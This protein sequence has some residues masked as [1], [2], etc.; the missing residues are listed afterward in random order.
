MDRD[1]NGHR[2]MPW[3][4]SLSVIAATV[5]SG[6]YG[7]TN[8]I[9]PQRRKELMRRLRIKRQVTQE[10]SRRL[11]AV[12]ARSRANI[13]NEQTITTIERLRRK[14]DCAVCELRASGAVMR[15]AVSEVRKYRDDLDQ[16][17]PIDTWRR[18]LEGK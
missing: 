3:L 14:L 2:T 11:A 6:L 5:F 18:S 7:W 12:C 8:L 1:A 4:S 10:E 16:C 17:G 15:E 9:E 13:A